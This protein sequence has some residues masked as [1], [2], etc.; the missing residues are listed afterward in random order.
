[1]SSTASV[2]LHL[3]TALGV[4]SGAD[5]EAGHIRA[6]AADLVHIR[7]GKVTRFVVYFDRTHAFA[8]LGLPDDRDACADS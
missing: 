8:D 5:W 1:V 3:P 7:G 4:A 2:R 6:E